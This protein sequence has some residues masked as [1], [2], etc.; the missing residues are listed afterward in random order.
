MRKLTCG[1]I[2]LTGRLH[3][4]KLIARCKQTAYPPNTMIHGHV[5]YGY[6]QG[7]VV[8]KTI[9]CR[10]CYLKIKTRRTFRKYLQIDLSIESSLA[11]ATSSFSGRTTMAD[12]PKLLAS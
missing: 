7:D 10:W 11:T 3:S 6:P 5:K 12:P 4:R 2:R 9:T 8:A 1:P